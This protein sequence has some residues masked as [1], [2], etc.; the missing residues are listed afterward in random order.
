MN[1]SFAL[2]LLPGLVIGLTVHE[3]A[4]AI[5]AKWLGDRNP[6]RM[7]RVSLNPLRHLSLLGTVS[8]FLLGFG[9]GKP[10][11]VNL[12]NF[13]KPKLYYLL[14]SLAGPV[15]NLLLSAAALG[16]MYMYNG[17]IVRYICLSVF[18]MNAILAVINLLPIPPL[19]GSKIWPCVIPGMRPTVSVKWTN[20]WTVVLI[21]CVFSG[22]IDKVMGPIV[23]ALASLLPMGG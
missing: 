19:D 18:F 9:W 11:L 8:L 20:I 6:E 17:T 4:H 22:V 2:I 14:S 1:I 15:S 23:R 5:T 10:V 7:G 3:F 13:K 16:I 12:Y 21:I